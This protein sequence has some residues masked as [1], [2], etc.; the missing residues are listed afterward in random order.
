[1]EIVDYIG[2]DWY[3]HHIV[4]NAMWLPFFFRILLICWSVSIV[5]LI[6]KKIIW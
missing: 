3:V 4:S 5:Y 1:M 2:A 6:L